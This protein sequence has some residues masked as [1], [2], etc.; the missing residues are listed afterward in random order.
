MVDGTSIGTT[1]TNVD[2]FALLGLDVC[3]EITESHCPCDDTF[4]TI[5]NS[6]TSYHTDDAEKSV[7]S[8]ETQF[9]AVG[10]SLAVSTMIVIVASI[11]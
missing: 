3:S 2:A 9:D 7:S 1:C 11:L 8:A 10:M 4:P 5:S 6:I